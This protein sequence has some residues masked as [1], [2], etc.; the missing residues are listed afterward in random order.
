MGRA[1][2]LPKTLDC[3][4]GRNEALYGAVLLAL[5]KKL[6]AIDEMSSSVELGKVFPWQGISPDMSVFLEE[7]LKPDDLAKFAVAKNLQ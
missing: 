7:L 3:C 4:L 2:S 5:I 6:D 1:G